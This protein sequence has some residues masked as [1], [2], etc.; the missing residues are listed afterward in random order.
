MELLW[1][2]HPEPTLCF[3]GDQAGR[4]AASRA[5][6]APLPMLKPG[7]SFRFAPGRR[8]QGPRRRAAEQ[9]P[10][11][12]R[13]QLSQ[14]TPFVQALFMRERDVERWTRPSAALP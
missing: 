7:K 9:G 12:L 8:G 14:T 11:V 1:R 4:Q 13:S 3:D 10:N 2:H 5:S 6:T